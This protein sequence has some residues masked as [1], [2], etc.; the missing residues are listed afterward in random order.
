MLIMLLSWVGCK[1]Q[2]QETGDAGAG[3]AYAER[4][5]AKCHAID[6]TSDSPEPAATP[7]RDVAKTPGMTPMALTVWLTTSHPTMPNI[8]LDKQD[9]DNVI[10]FILTLRND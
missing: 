7:F 8:V 1:V 9:L 4:V 10:A 5:C 3:A 2:A 6:L